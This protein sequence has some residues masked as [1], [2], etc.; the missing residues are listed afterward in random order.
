MSIFL[1]IGATSPVTYN[2]VGHFKTVIILTASFILFASPLNAKNILGM[3]L[4][5]GGMIMYTHFKMQAA[6]VRAAVAADVAA[7]AVLTC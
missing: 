6:K 4:A 1:V 3:S 2:V 5:L 7:A